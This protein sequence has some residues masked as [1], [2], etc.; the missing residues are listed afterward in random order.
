MHMLMRLETMTQLFKD[1]YWGKL[2]RTTKTHY[3]NDV[4]IQSTANAILELSDWTQIP[5]NGLTSDC[6]TAFTTYRASIRTIRKT[7]P[8][9]PTWPDAPTEEW[10]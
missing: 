4:C 5:N 2:W 10:S 9:N 3:L 1:F 6:V 8:A 7:N